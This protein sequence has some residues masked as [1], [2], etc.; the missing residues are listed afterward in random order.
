[1]AANGKLRLELRINAPARH[2]IRH[3]GRQSSQVINLAFDLGND[4]TNEAPHVVVGAICD[5]DLEAILIQWRLISNRIDVVLVDCEGSL[6]GAA[7]GASV[8]VVLEG[9]VEFGDS[10]VQLS[11]Q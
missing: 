1:M 8:E 5:C 9:V 4:T 10:E 2:R 6:A 7:G 11:E 3:K